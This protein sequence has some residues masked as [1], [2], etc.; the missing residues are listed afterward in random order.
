MNLDVPP[1]VLNFNRARYGYLKN[2]TPHERLE[3]LL[4][5][6][7]MAVISLE[8]REEIKHVLLESETKTRAWY[9]DNKVQ[10]LSA[11][12]HVWLHHL[13][14][15]IPPDV[16]GMHR[17][18]IWITGNLHWER[19]MGDALEELWQGVWTDEMITL[20]PS[21]YTT[22]IRLGIMPFVPESMRETWPLRVR[23]FAINVERA[24]A[25]KRLDRALL[26]PHVVSRRLLMNGIS[27]AWMDLLDEDEHETNGLLSQKQRAAFVLTMLML[28][29]RFKGVAVDNKYELIPGKAAVDLSGLSKSKD[30]TI[31]VIRPINLDVAATVSTSS[32][33]RMGAFVHAFFVSREAYI[34]ASEKRGSDLTDIES[35]RYTLNLLRKEVK[36]YIE[37]TF[38]GLLRFGESTHL[39]RKIYLQLAFDTFGKNMKETGFAAKVFA[40]EGYATALH[41]T[42]VIIED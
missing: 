31:K 5:P 40:H 15:E 32:H 19:E 12:G 35:V 1:L 38:P 18:L 41:Y 3:P 8:I 39:L 37:Q 21:P 34:K 16:E 13:F 33:E 6:S 42:S 10:W 26:T 22:F 7:V 29:S 28:G 4:V 27:I 24:R 17:C 23:E 30:P 20:Y 11:T 9:Y 14:P 2:S 25:V 36:R